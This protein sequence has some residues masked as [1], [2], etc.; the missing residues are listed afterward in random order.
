MPSDPVARKRS[1]TT[2]T[3]TLASVKGEEPAEANVAATFG[4]KSGKGEKTGVD[5]RYHT[6]NE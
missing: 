2:K 3:G 1:K 6:G 4:D 5:M